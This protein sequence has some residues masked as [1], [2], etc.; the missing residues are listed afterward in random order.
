[1]TL[2]TVVMLGDWL[3]ENS[4]LKHLEYVMCRSNSVVGCAVLA[5]ICH[6]SFM[7]ARCTFL[8]RASVSQNMFRDEGL[9]KII[10][11]LKHNTVL[12]SLM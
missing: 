4:S 12:A 8:T 9:A 11:V 1:M 10:A 7:T 3:V 5:Y 2:D 6:R